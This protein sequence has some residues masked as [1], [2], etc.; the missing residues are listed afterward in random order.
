MTVWDGTYLESEKC[1]I[2]LFRGRY[3]EST[4][5][6]SVYGQ[7]ENVLVKHATFAIGYVTAI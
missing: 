7:T 6:V 3:R 5:K 1:T 4:K 2:L